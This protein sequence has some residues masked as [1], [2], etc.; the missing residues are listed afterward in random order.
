MFPSFNPG[1]I[2]M[3]VSL[4][5]GL[6]WAQKFGFQGY[7]FPIAQTMEYANE[8]SP[9]AL[10][11]LFAK[12]N[13]KIGNWNLPFSPT[14]PEEAWKEG[15]ENLKPAAELA[16]KI[17]ALRTAMWIIPGSDELEY[18]ANWDLHVTRYQA[19]EKI[20]R[21]HGIRIGLEFIGP[22]TSRKKKKY[23]FM[24]TLP[25][26]RKL[27]K[28]V[29]PNAGLLIDSWHW[30]CSGG[31]REQMADL[32]NDEIV[33]IH[34]NDAPAGIAREEQIDN[35]RRMPG[36]TEVIDIDGFLQALKAANYDGPVTAEPFED[37]TNALPPDEKVKINAD[38]VIGVMRRNG[39]VD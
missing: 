22:E 4:E 25:E 31:T 6:G 12:Y 29:G 17:G 1:H 36:T 39:L 18:E 3:S 34:I 8:N 37:T 32:S 7:D 15:L 9:E 2:K 24:H 23:P 27:A 13:Q 5:E 16:E 38:C 20:L 11:D 33:H 30:Y 21:P 28:E 26:A 19:V 14:G 35:Q 10:V